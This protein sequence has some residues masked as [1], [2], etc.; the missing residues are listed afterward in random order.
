MAKRKGEMLAR[1]DAAVALPGGL[2]TLDELFDAL[3]LRRI[4]GGH[5]KP[6]G[7]LNINGYYDRLLDFFDCVKASG[8]SVRIGRDLICVG[9]SPEDLFVKLRGNMPPL[10]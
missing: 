6:I 9:P 4:K 7:I 10:V 8:F 2:G 3:A 1:A 5:K